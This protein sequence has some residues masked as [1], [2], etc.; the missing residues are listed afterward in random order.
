MEGNEGYK[1]VGARANLKNHYS[2]LNMMSIQRYSNQ[3][4]NTY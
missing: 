2:P 1:N 3:S 4:R